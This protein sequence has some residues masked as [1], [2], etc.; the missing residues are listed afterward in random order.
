MKEIV[1]QYNF[2][3]SILIIKNKIRSTDTFRFELV[4]LSVIQNEIKS[5][6]PNKAAIHNNIPPKILR[7]SLEATADSF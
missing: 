7:Q 2:H 5:L 6:N 1:V 3:L 4:T